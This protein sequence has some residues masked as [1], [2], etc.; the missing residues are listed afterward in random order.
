MKHKLIA[1]TAVLFALLTA[2]FAAEVSGKWKAQVPGRNGT[3]D[4][5]FEFKAAGSAVTGT[6]SVEGQ[7]V[8]LA[9]GKLSGDTLSFTVALDRGGNMIKYTYTGNIAGNEIQYKRESG[10]GQPREFTAKRA[11]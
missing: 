3:R 11:N 7:S 9:D 5:T 2:V 1:V 10:Q 8:A 4:T 6:M